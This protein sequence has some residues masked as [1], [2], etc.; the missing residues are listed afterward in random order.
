[1]DNGGVETVEMKK[2]KSKS[3]NPKKLQMPNSNLEADF[4]AGH[5]GFG[6]WDF[7]GV[8]DLDFGI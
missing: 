8:W 7:F 1:M 4:W 5:F 3:K 2:P 6:I